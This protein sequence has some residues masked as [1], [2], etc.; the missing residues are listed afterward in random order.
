MSWDTAVW[1]VWLYGNSLILWGFAF[2]TVWFS[3]F[4]LVD[5]FFKGGKRAPSTKAPLLSYSSVW[6]WPGTLGVWRFL[7]WWGEHRLFEAQLW[8]LEFTMLCLWWL[9][10]KPGLMIFSWRLRSCCQPE[11]CCPG[12]STFWCSSLQNLPSLALLESLHPIILAVRKPGPLCLFVLW[13]G[14][15]LV[16]SWC[17]SLMQGLL[18]CS[19]WILQGLKTCFRCI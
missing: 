5:F 18:A 13:L 2:L 10:H 16:E 8:A 12:H 1:A 9:W 6:I 4:S 17:N 11:A 15:L 3:R 19:V 14:Y 7:L